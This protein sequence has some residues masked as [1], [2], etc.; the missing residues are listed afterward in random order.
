MRSL[1][2]AR[3]PTILTNPVPAFKTHTDKLFWLEQWNIGRQQP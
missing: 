3:T 1:T 2:Q